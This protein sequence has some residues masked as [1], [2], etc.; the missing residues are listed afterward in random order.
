MQ[1]AQVLQEPQAEIQMN[2]GR[3]ILF[4]DGVCVMCNDGLEFITE[5]DRQDLFRF[6]PVQSRF[7]QELLTRHGRNAA[8][9]DT[10]YI[11]IDYGTP[12]ERFVWKHKAVTFMMS[13]LGWR[14]WL[15][16]KLM[17]L[18]PTALGD[19]NYDRSARTRYE[20]YGKYDACPMPPP[21]VR[22]KLLT[23]A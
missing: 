2:G 14:F 8:D 6:A 1:A 11:V 3:Y 12:R 15:M 4:Y 19:W 10:V 20:R 18:V 23:L 21:E 17:G 13:Q 9:L 7:A 5:N 22:R 16:S